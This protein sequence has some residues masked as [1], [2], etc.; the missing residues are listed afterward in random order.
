VYDLEESVSTFYL[1]KGALE[2]R[3]GSVGGVDELLWVA[4]Q[5]DYEASLHGA[6]VAAVLE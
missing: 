6:L 1:K 3:C 5:H 2:V 4:T